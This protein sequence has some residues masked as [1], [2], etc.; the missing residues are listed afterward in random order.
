MARRDLLQLSFA[1]TVCALLLLV[2][3]V[4]VASGSSPAATQEQF[5]VISEP[6]QYAARM[7]ATAPGLRA[8]LFIDTLF[9][10]AYT[11]A[12]GAAAIAFCANSRPAAWFAGLGIVAVMLL[13]ALENAT[14]VQSLDIVALTGSVGMERIAYQATVSAM[15]WQAAAAALLAMSFVL[16]SATPVEK[17]LVWG[18]RLGLPVAVPLFVFDA[19][20]MREWGGMLLLASMAAGFVLLAIV[21]RGHARTA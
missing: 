2:A 8:V 21:V 19:F 7:A 14:M 18:V 5:E 15:K 13:D 10:L 16:P 17:L 1:A 12:I 4:A 11:V 20:A 9:L 3:A 6:A